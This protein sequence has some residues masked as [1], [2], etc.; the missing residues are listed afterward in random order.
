MKPVRLD[1][2]Y[3]LGICLMV[4]ID[5][6]ILSRGMAIDDIRIRDGENR[7]IVNQNEYRAK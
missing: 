6:S 4:T 5:I 2:N 7:E 1:I 3:I